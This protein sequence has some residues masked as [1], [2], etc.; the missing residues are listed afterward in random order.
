MKFIALFLLLSALSI[1]AMENESTQKPSLI[2]MIKED[3]NA[4]PSINNNKEETFALNFN[5]CCRDWK[6][7]PYSQYTDDIDERQTGKYSFTASYCKEG[8]RCC[9]IDCF[10]IGLLCCHH[11]WKCNVEDGRC[12]VNSICYDNRRGGSGGVGDDDNC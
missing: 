1:S 7:E 3:T 2:Q 9:C 5:S 11:Q 4:V 6:R 12:Y 10:F 8:I